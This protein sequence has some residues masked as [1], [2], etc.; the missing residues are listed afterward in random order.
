ME[1]NVFEGFAQEVISLKEERTQISN[2]IT[3]AV[4][5]FAE[6]HNIDKKVVRKGVTVYEGYLKDSAEALEFAA[7]V[8]DICFEDAVDTEV[9]NT[10][11]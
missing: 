9:G 7:I 10:E 6:E 8:N 11:D 2:Q 3:E 5:A 4:N 1:K